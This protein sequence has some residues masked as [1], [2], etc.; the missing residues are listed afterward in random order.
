MRGEYKEFQLLKK[1]SRWKWS[2]D[3]TKSGI[4]YEA[5]YMKNQGNSVSHAQKGG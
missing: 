3:D 1:M 4:G 5:Q 2:K